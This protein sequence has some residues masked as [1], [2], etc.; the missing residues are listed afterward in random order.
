MFFSY[1]KLVYRNA[2][3][4]GIN[5]ARQYNDT[6][7]RMNSLPLQKK[8]LLAS[9]TNDVYEIH[10]LSN[11]RSARVRARLATNRNINNSVALRLANDI[12]YGVR[13]GLIAHPKKLH[14]RILRALLLN[15]K[16]GSN[17]IRA[18]FVFNRYNMG[19][20][21]DADIQRALIAT[22]VTV[23]GRPFGL[24]AHP[25]L[26]YW[27]LD[28]HIL[29]DVVNKA[30]STGSPYLQSRTWSSSSVNMWY[31]G[32][33]MHSYFSH[34]IRQKHITPD[35]INKI[36]SKNFN[37]LDIASHAKTPQVT[38]LHFASLK[39]ADL[40]KLYKRPI[41]KLEKA[42]R[43]LQLLLTGHPK[44]NAVILGILRTSKYEDV[45]LKVAHHKK[46][47]ILDLKLLTDPNFEKSARVRKIAQINLKRRSQ[48]NRP[49]P[50]P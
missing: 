9:T 44:V 13:L 34:L 2:E 37:F 32:F 11:D 21:I 47:N 39:V 42:I 48:A 31:N 24:W 49:R 46:T 25:K 16:V 23:R 26:L 18:Q 35:L 7:T 33:P 6:L 43:D 17:K 19:E 5:N 1:S 36:A 12:S 4:G 22:R 14:I 10:V 8:L 29:A 41:P 50:R 30:I 28:P 15:R 45:R 40:Q 38:L 3:S 27:E 20:Y